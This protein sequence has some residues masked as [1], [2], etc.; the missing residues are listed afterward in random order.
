MTRLACCIRVVI[1]VA[2]LLPFT[3]CRRTADQ[4]LVSPDSFL[5]CPEPASWP[6]PVTRQVGSAGDSLALGDSYFVIPPNAIPGSSTRTITISPIQSQNVGVEIT[7]EPRGG[8]AN[9]LTATLAIGLTRCDPG[10]VGD[11]ARWSIW[12]MRNATTG[13]PLSTQVGNGR[14]QTQRDST[15]SFMIAN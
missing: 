12:L 3:G 1:A 8:F 7:S 6:T 9:G 5:T 4:G 2:L 10:I 11:T 15:S 13:R 14:L